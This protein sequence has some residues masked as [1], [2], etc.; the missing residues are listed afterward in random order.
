ME[1]KTIDKKH[2]KT[3]LIRGAFMLLFLVISRI[4]SICVALIAVFQFLCALIVR[5]P[6]N[7]AMRFGKELSLYL[8]EIV[9]FLSYNIEKKP[10]PFSPWLQTGPANTTHEGQ[11]DR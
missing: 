4:V 5:K 9:Q 2:F 11:Q 10:W 7:N 8:A 3:D 1:D 6:N